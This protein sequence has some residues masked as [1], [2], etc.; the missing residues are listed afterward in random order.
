[1]Y[2]WQLYEKIKDAAL[3]AYAADGN[4]YMLGLGNTLYNKLK[5][6]GFTKEQAMST[7]FGAFACVACNDGKISYAEHE[8]FKKMIGDPSLSYDDF[9]DVMSKYNRQESRNQTVDSFNAI[10]NPTTAL[11]F[12]KLC[13]MVSVVDGSIHTNEE[14]FCTS[15]CEVYLN[16]F[17]Y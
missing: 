10:N 8:S 16:R 9:F 6:Q 5:D 2:A 7:V 3:K 17:D 4:A 11:D 15:L 1:M 12:I 14:M 13:V